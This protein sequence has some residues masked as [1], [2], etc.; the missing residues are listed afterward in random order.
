[1]KCELIFGCFLHV[2]EAKVSQGH[3]RHEGDGFIHDFA[4]A[5]IQ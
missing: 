1:M 5:L 4:E 2:V 3:L